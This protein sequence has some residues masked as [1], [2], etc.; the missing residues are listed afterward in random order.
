M[1]KPEAHSPMSPHWPFVM[2]LPQV[3]MTQAMPPPHWSFDV[4]GAQTPLMQAYP[5]AAAKPGC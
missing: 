5:V 2:Q 3:P 1:Q 4:H